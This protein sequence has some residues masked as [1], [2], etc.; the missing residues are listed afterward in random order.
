MPN[1]KTGGFVL[2]ESFSKDNPQSLE[3]QILTYELILQQ[4]G[5]FQQRPSNANEVFD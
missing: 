4:N 3:H 1:G 5:N 2:H